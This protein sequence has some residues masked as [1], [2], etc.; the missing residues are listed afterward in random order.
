MGLDVRWILF[1]AGCYVVLGVVNG[2]LLKESSL[3]CGWQASGAGRVVFTLAGITAPVEFI[4]DN[5]NC[6]LSLGRRMQT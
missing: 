5:A 4:R 2:V 6:R 3:F 1:L